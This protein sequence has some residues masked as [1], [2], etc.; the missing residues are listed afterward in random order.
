MDF[1]NSVKTSQ[2]H[3]VLKQA[4]ILPLKVE[5][6]VK[7]H[8][9]LPIADSEVYDIMYAFLQDYFKFMDLLTLITREVLTQKRM[10]DMA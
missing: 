7:R 2:A 8:P 3:I 6:K 1:I 10:Q 9:T 5:L 4:K